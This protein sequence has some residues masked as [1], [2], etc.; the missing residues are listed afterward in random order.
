MQKVVGSSPII[1][2]AESPAQAGFFVG[3]CEGTPTAWAAS[4]SIMKANGH[5][6]RRCS[7]GSPVRTRSPITR[8]R[9]TARAS[10]T[11]TRERRRRGRGRVGRRRLANFYAEEARLWIS[12]RRS[13]RSALTRQSP[14]GA[15]ARRMSR[16]SESQASNRTPARR[17]TSSSSEGLTGIGPHRRTS[18]GLGPSSFGVPGASPIQTSAASRARRRTSRSP[19]RPAASP[20]SSSRR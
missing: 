7:A 14:F 9:R 19:G 11:E 10:T 3:S 8:A 4:R 1:R 6:P 13:R 17:R 18:F 16:R 12:D 20:S 2:F 15:P 5:A